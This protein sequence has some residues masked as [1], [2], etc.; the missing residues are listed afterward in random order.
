MRHKLPYQHDTREKGASLSD[1]VVAQQTMECEQDWHGKE[2]LE[3]SVSKAGQ[4]A[5]SKIDRHGWSD[6]Y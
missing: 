5:H 1:G 6:F 3:R 2:R 4:A